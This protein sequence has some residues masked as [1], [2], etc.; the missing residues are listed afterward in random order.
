MIQSMLKLTLGQI[1]KRQNFIQRRNIEVTRSS[2]G[3]SL[4]HQA[5]PVL[6]QKNLRSTPKYQIEA[7]QHWPLDH[8]HLQPSA[9]IELTFKF[10][11]TLL[12]N[13]HFSVKGNCLLY[14]LIIY[15]IV[16]I[17]QFP[18]N[19]TREAMQIY[20]ITLLINFHFSVKGAQKT[21]AVRDR[22]QKCAGQTFIDS[23]QTFESFFPSIKEGDKNKL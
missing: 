19:D 22:S 12:I 15:T 10:L 1:S 14:I 11:I 2:R 3:K 23:N 21:V 17:V 18:Q 4:G 16:N 6:F 8:T 20:L 5:G 7:Q 9:V 13:F